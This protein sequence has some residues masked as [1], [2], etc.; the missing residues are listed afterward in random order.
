MISYELTIQE[1]V[2]IMM[3]PYLDS[4]EFLFWIKYKRYPVLNWTRDFI[5]LNVSQNFNTTNYGKWWIPIRIIPNH[6]FPLGSI[7][8]TLS[9]Q[10]PIL[11]TFRSIKDDWIMIDNQQAGK[12]VPQN[13]LYILCNYFLVIEYLLLSYKFLFIIVMNTKIP[14]VV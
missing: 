10:E 3:D 12:Y 2:A 11:S 8:Q 14:Y 6:F 5:Y 1:I 9:S 13:Y 4:N 7:P